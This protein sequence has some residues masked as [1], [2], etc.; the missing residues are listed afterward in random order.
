[1]HSQVTWIS[2][3]YVL[4]CAIGHEVGLIQSVEL[5]KELTLLLTAAKSKL[6]ILFNIAAMEHTEINLTLLST[7]LLPLLYY[8]ACGWVILYG[9]D[10]EADQLFDLSFT[11][12]YRT[13]FRTCGTQQEAL[14]LLKAKDKRLL[15][16]ET[17]HPELPMITES[18]T[19]PE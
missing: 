2:E 16:N 12:T 4:E 6:H 1:M 3:G 15:L 19:Y 9:V 8:P 13:R 14:D 17:E 5:S 11:R 10:H 18:A 7:V